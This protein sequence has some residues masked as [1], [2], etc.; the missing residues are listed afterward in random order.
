MTSTNR[1]AVIYCRVSK[2][3]RGRAKSVGEQERE[4]RATCDEHRWEVRQVVIDND[5]SASEYA[6]KDRPGYQQLS[7]ILRTGDVLVMWEPSRLT[8]QRREVEDLIDLCQSRDVLIAVADGQTY[9]L[10]RGR[11]RHALFAD[12]NNAAYESDKT[13]ERV[14][15]AHRAVLAAGRPHGRI[16]YGYRADTDD[17][18]VITGR[19]PHPIHGPIVTDMYRKV[20]DGVTPWRIA[21]DLTRA[22]VSP[23][24]KF[25]AWTHSLIVRMLQRP[26]YKGVRTSQ[27]VETGPGTWEPLIDPRTWDRVHRILNDPKRK[28]TRGNRPKYLL[29][30]I[31]V[32]S[33][34]ERPVGRMKN[35]QGVPVYQCP[36]GHALRSIEAV[37]AVVEAKM[38]E[39]LQDPKVIARLE[40]A[41]NTQ[42]DHDPIDLVH[43][44]Q[45]TLDAQ[46]EAVVAQ[47]L[48]P[49]MTAR[50]LQALH[51]KWTPQIE[52]AQ[53]DAQRA[54]IDPQLVK[55]TGAAG[56]RFW[57]GFSLEAKRHAI[58]SAL[59]IKI[60]PVGRGK[61][62]YKI[63]DTLEIDW[64]A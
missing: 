39:Y 6:R 16:P 4:C 45:A 58:R 31:A 49:A 51:D 44:L 50:S 26:T 15:R 28:V 59:S 23:P 46:I 22:S 1:Q 27:G 57:K 56:V 19:S 32:C 18:G 2:D 41:Q 43:D 38:L 9:D 42:S 14:L 29:S 12:I 48:P 8:R 47:E 61:K 10:T 3:T 33:V 21:Q 5:L 13:Q 52:A 60:L 40:T 24:G 17:H 55:L 35:R 54:V 25:P 64:I 30:G 53:A 34:C 62:N 11:D 7:A 63:E 36:D 37:D 20:A